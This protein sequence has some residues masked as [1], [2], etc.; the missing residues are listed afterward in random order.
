MKQ[1]EQ[2]TKEVKQRFIPT[3]WVIGLLIFANTMICYFDRVNFSVAAP[4]IMKLFHWDM[5]ILGLAMSMF[6]VGYIFTQIPAGL[7]SDRFGGRKILAAGSMGWSFFTIL[8]PWAATPL[9]MYLVRGM[10][11]LAE[12]LN[13]PGSTSVLSRWVPR[14]ARARIQGLNLSGVAAGP[15]IATPLTLWIMT[16]FGL[17]AMF[18]FYGILGFLWTAVWL[19]Y[20]T[21]NPAEHK[22]MT[23]EDLK[24]IE[25]GQVAEATVSV[26]D[27]PIR[28]KGVWGLATAYFCFTY[29]WWLFLNWL[30]TYLVQV[31]GYTTIKM[32]FF[33]SLPWL[34]ALIS[35]NGAGWLSDALVKRGF[36]IGSARRTL[37]YVGAPAMAVCL[38]FVTQAGNAEVAVGLITITISLAGMN[39]PAFWSLP[40]DMN[41]QKAGFITGMMNTGSALASTV[42]PGVTG[43]VAMWFGWTAALGLGSV[44]ALLSAI[45][46]CFTLSRPISNQRGA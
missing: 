34:A 24:E 23:R 20:S 17:K 31:R 3:Y 2:I 36:S 45:I 19:L 11:G 32:G 4:T 12:G 15:L 27:V 28:S 8:T 1:P 26:G 37:I 44:L 14:K 21:D 13:F 29:T 33:A 25:E 42:A 6:G 10:L 35:T 38:W 40:M 39:F 43:Y 16:T 9:L 7:L 30:P 46:M 41:V 18:C 5:G 22:G